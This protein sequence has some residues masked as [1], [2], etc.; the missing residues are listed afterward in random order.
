[1]SAPKKKSP[2]KK[3]HKRLGPVTFRP[4]WND[5]AAETWIQIFR[6]RDQVK[7]AASLARIDEHDDGYHPISYQLE[8]G[9]RY[10]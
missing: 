9:V 6:M 5:R 2:G 7:L 3:S 1:M 8:K 10:L 4:T